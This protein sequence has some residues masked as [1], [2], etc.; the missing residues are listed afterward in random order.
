MKTLQ[1][2]LDAALDQVIQVI[3]VKRALETEHNI[4]DIKTISFHAHAHAHA[5]AYVH[6]TF[7]QIETLVCL[8]NKQLSHLNK[9]LTVSTLSILLSPSSQADSISTSAQES[10]QFLTVCVGLPEWEDCAEVDEIIAAGV[11]RFCERLSSSLS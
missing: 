1:E 6:S 9:Y 11:T 3:E 2:I 5:H 8:A 10:E 7:E 4:Q